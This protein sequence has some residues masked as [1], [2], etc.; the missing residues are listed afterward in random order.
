MKFIDLSVECDRETVLATICDSVYVND[1]V[2]FDEKKGKPKMTVKEKGDSIR[3]KCEMIGGATR[4]NGFLI[5]TYFSGKLIEQNGQ[6]KLKGII[7]TDPIYPILLCLLLGFFVYQ[8]F[9]LGG[10]SPVP[11]IF[12]AFG[13]FMMRKEYSK[14]GTIERYLARAFRKAPDYKHKK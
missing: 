12:F 8:C 13:I 7:L 9:A 2:Q 1:R 5:G 3:I 11:L 10:F 4:D 14:Q 6:T